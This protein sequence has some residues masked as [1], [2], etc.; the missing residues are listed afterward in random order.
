MAED[1]KKEERVYASDYDVQILKLPLEKKRVL[2]R[3]KGLAV[4]SDEAFDIPLLN[5]FLGKVGLDAFIGLI[6]AA[7][8]GITLIFPLMIAAQAFTLGAPLR[9]WGWIVAKYAAKDALLGIV[10]VLGDYLDAKNRANTQTFIEIYDWAEKKFGRA[11]SGAEVLE[12]IQTEKS[13]AAQIV[14]EA[15]IVFQKDIAAA[16]RDAK[17]KKKPLEAL[18]EEDK[19]RLTGL[20][21]DTTTQISL[22]ETGN[23]DAASAALNNL[24]WLR[25]E[26][27]RTLFGDIE[28]SSMVLN[29]V[30]RA[31]T[32]L[33]RNK[34]NENIRKLLLEINAKRVRIKKD[35]VD[36][37]MRKRQ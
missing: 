11:E 22:A 14:L 8:D 20:A 37:V 6:P 19:Q 32:V 3:I 31:E 23:T 30:T 5:K 12:E 26:A 18:S 17:E 29:A 15:L 36:S 1:E 34:D 25:L 21:E 28:G 16:W 24:V 35:F 4:T 9:I 10:P 27:S 7:G 13:E 33:A 2:E